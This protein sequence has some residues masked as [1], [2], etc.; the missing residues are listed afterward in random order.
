MRHAYEVL[1]EASPDM[2]TR[3]LQGLSNFDA[4][5]VNDLRAVLLS[6][7][8]LNAVGNALIELPTGIDPALTRAAQASENVWRRVEHEFGLL[9][10]SEVADL[11]GA[12]NRNRAYASNRR[13]RGELL[14][15]MR[16]HAYVFPG[17]QFNR[18]AGEIRP[19]V[20]PVLEL[21]ESNSCAAADVVMWMMSPTTYFDGDRPADH[22]D[23]AA[24]L[25]D[26][27]ERA[28]GVEW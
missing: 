25:L 2:L 10:S 22:V 20:K 4:S 27:A 14:A 1:S 9:S 15:T 16:R 24:R 5:F 23:D 8:N 21:A 19:W 11:L 7:L 6:K 13:Q 26:V 12:R 17:F 28:W 18:S 3:G